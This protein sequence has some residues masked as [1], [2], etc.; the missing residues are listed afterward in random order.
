MTMV[1]VV[2]RGRV[3]VVV[4]GRVVVVVVRGRVVVVV[5]RGRV[6]VV[7]VDGGGAVGGGGGGPSNRVD[8]VRG[9]SMVTG[10]VVAA[11]EQPGAPQ[12]T[13][14]APGSGMAVSFT[15]LPAS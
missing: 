5:V 4:R 2:V 14:S 3:V 1:V 7:V 15:L 12:L 11:L 10:Q 8:R 13:R 9:S 6:V